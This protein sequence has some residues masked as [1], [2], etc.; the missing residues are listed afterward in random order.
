MYMLWTGC[1]NVYLN[2]NLNLNH[3]N[4]C[5]L[6]VAE[7]AIGFPYSQPPKLSTQTSTQRSDKLRYP[8]RKKKTPLAQTRKNMIVLIYYKFVFKIQD[9]VMKWKCFP[10]YW[11]FVRE[12][13]RSLVNSPHKGQWRGALIFSFYLGVNNWLS[14]PSRRRWFE[15]PSRSL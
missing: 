8:P 4:F 11:P 10:R 15:T 1:N 3:T 7:F 12:I 6:T 2:L 14:K 9:D 13:H 5:Y